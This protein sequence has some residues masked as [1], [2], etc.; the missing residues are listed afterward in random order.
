MGPGPDVAK[1]GALPPEKIIFF[2]PIS[3]ITFTDFIEVYREVVKGYAHGKLIVS[4]D[5]VNSPASA[6]SVQPLL[7]VDVQIVGWTNGV[8][9]TLAWGATGMQE[10]AGTP[11]VPSNGN[12]DAPPVQTTWDDS[13]GFDE[14]SV[15]LRTM[16]NG[17]VPL[18]NT[19]GADPWLVVAGDSINVNIAGKLWR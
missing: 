3:A 8:P 5:V 18:T 9:E 11:L 1:P 14:I 6:V 17:G 2:G 10:Q 15:L 12:M 13:F 19:Y 16:G 4:A 7:Y